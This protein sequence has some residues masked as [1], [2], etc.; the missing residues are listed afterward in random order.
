MEKQIKKITF[1]D[2]ENKIY[3]IVCE[4]GCEILKKI[5]E[6]QD[7]YLMDTRNT[8]EYRHSGYK[9][10][11]IKTV[12]GEVSYKRILYK[13]GKEY[14][15][16]L[17]EALK[18][19]KIGEI[20]Y[21]LVEQ[22]L[23]TV[24]NTTSYRKA[25]EEIKNLTN[26]TISH[27]AIHSLVWQVGKMIEERENK[28]IKLY[29]EGK[30]FEG[31]KSI[32]VLFEEAD[33]LWFH[34]QGKD[35]KEALEKYKKECEKKNKE[36]NLKQKFN[37]EIKLYVSY[38][39]WNKYSTRKEL[40]NKKLIAGMMTPK[41]LKELKNARIYQQYK[42]DNIVLRASNG[43]GA[44]WINNI[45][46]K[47]T[48]TQK[49]S[50]HIQQEILRDVLI[51]KYR[52]E[53]I[54]LIEDKK[55][56][57]VPKYIEWLKYELGGDEKVIK[58]LEKLKKY[59]KTGLPRYTDILKKQGR[60]LPKAP[61]G[62]EY[63]NMGTMESQIFSVLVVR[64]C[65][66]RKAFLKIGANYLAKICA[67]YYEN[68]EITLE[69]VEKEIPI[70]NSIEEWIKEIE[71]NA[72]KNKKLHRADKKMTEENHFAKANIIDYSLELKELLKLAEPTALMYR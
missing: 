70:D 35:R 66:G 44:S 46:N 5:L 50:F 29:K 3:K 1:Y 68:N 26:Q 27:Q 62:I 28:E 61:K 19:D 12:M 45:M 25:E 56:D 30:L 53:L 39:G 42:E 31:T 22:I 10:T 23:R 65:S 11:T 59:L 18:I 49:D 41:K 38:E 57:D 2:L 8:K 36:I 63:R 48:I 16:L 60:E 7:K 14:V 21:N 40:V 24:V 55:Y 15:F 34:L 47:D 58:K 9:D 72:K 20:S 37:S 54:K 6:S 64:L 52:E 17:D 43:D 13:K 4:L 71:E 51:K 33:G 32:P 69:K 67:E